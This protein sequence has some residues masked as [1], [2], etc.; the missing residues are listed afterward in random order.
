M[1]GI[2]LRFGNKEM[3]VILQVRWGNETS[4]GERETPKDQ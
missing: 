2:G 4:Y 1:H 3:T